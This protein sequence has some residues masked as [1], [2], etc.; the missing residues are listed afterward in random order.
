MQNCGVKKRTGARSYDS[1][2]YAFQGGGGKEK[3]ETVQENTPTS[4]SRAKK[5]KKKEKGW[6]NSVRSQKDPTE[7][8]RRGGGKST[9]N[10]KKK[11]RNEREN[12]SRGS[13]FFR[14]PVRGRREKE[15][16][17]AV[18]FLARTS[19]LTHLNPYIKRRKGGNYGG[20]VSLTVAEVG[21][22]KNWKCVL[23]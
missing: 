7:G 11:K 14:L 8:G 10:L 3:R 4:A 9:G 15:G 22:K 21:E 17:N 2:Q 20:R 1:R 12:H 13:L 19:S 16:R 18:S 6:K 23:S 5:K